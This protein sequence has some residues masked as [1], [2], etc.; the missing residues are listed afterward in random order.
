MT[1]FSR[2][3]SPRG[4]WRVWALALLLTCT[5]AS[6]TVAQNNPPPARIVAIGDIHGDFDAF[7]GILKHAGLTD[8]S[9]RWSAGNATFV[10]VGDFTDRGA[11]VRPVMDL[12]MDLEEQ[13]KAAGGRV[14]VLLGNHEVLNLIGEGRDVTPAIYGTFADDQSEQR[15]VA[16]YEAYLKL[17]AMRGTQLRSL[18]RLYQP[19]SK[20]AW[21]AAHPLGFVEYREALSPQGQYGRWLRAKA[22]VVRVDDSVFMHAGINPDRAPRNLEDINKQVAAEI[23]RFDEYRNRMVDRKLILPFFTLEEVLVAAQIEVQ[24]GAVASSGPS[25][26]PSSPGGFDSLTIPDSL[27]LRGLLGINSW[28]LVDPEGP[29]WFRGFATWSSEVGA[30][31]SRFLL[32]RYNVAHFVVGHTIMPSRRIT[33]RFSS[34]VFLIDTGMLSSYA[35]RGV[36]S[37]LEISDGRFSAIYADE[38]TTLLEREAGSRR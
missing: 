7:V 28:A 35:P 15:R 20:D 29:L 31:Q 33:P 5:P 14:V 25:A 10:Q 6:R 2:A 36:A 21:M 24:A 4:V 32:R 9:G 1:T 16:A 17:C 13:A 19:L 3:R 23:K 12:L 30:V 11:K 8:A 18:P 34:A 22:P 26:D 38:R 27:G 37:A